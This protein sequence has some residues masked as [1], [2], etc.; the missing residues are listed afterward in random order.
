VCR[1][2]YL[3]LLQLRGFYS[4][5]TNSNRGYAY[6][7]IGPQEQIPGISTLNDA[8]VPLPLAIG[9]KALWEA[10]VELRIPVYEKLGMVIFVD[11]SDVR[12][13][14]ADFAAQFAPH[15]S[16]GLGIRYATP[17]G[18]LRADLGLR[19]P[20]AQVI[21]FAAQCAAFDPG[22]SPVATQICKSG[23]PPPNNPY[24]DQKFGQAGSLR[25]VPLA[26]SLAIGE[27]F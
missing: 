18:P 1:G 5:G 11:G 16:T 24:L 27:A 8:Y 19:I 13:K 3:Q 4:G 25:G 21:G 10:S 26:L 14:L 20:G 6:N 9:G 12:D 22:A 17:V 23:Q 15:L 7:G 2:R